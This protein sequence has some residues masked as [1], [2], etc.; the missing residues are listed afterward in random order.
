MFAEP[1][2]FWPAGL[3]DSDDEDQSNDG[4]SNDEFEIVEDEDQDHIQVG[5]DPLCAIQ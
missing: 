2:L 5:L 3:D 4:D 1:A